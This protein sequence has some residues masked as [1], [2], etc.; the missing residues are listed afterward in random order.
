MHAVAT[1]RSLVTLNV[2]SYY[3]LI[4]CT[5]TLV[6]GLAEPTLPFLIV[7]A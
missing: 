3:I 6:A 4:H 1:P 5:R 7:S 2:Y